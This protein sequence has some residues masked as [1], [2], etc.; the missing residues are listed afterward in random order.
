[1][2]TA[3]PVFANIAFLRIAGF[4]ARAVAD[5]ARLKGRLEARL[6]EAIAGLPAADRI[7]LDAPDGMALV[8]FGAPARALDLVQALCAAAGEE[9]L[10]AGLNHGPIAVTARDA[11][12]MVFGDGISSA[13]TAS[14]FAPG[15]RILVTA[16]FAK[17][18]EAT[19][20]DRAAEL[21][22]AGEFTDA[23]V[24]LHA[25]YSPE[26][27]RL[28]ARRNRLAAYALVGMLAILLLGVIGREVNSR[29]FPPRPAVVEFDV[30]PWGEVVIDGVA[31]GRTPLDLREVELPPGRHQIRVRSGRYPPL[32][33]KVS[34]EPGERMTVTHSFTGERADQRPGSFWRDLWRGKVR[35]P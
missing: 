2:P 11:G 26:P 20:P 25:F 19:Q 7:V 23:R 10:K 29:Y 4:A 1:M 31:R 34:L 28:I 35:W 33:L 6:R 8:H 27:K 22:P 24:R 21:A 5:Q 14:G 32:D 3:S 17:M 18:L 15:D 9:P 16:P 30:K 13:A 12:A